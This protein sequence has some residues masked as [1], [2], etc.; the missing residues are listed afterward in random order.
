V[1]HPAPKLTVTADAYVINIHDRIVGSSSLYGSG[2]AVNSPAVVAAINANGNVLDPTVTQTGINIFTNAAN[3]RN[4]GLELLLSY[5]SNYGDMDRVDW[6]P[7]GNYNK[8]EVTKINQAPAQLLPQLLLNLGAIAS[9]EESSPRARVNFGALWKNHG[10][11]VN[12][13]ESVYGPSAG[14]T[15]VNGTLYFKSEIK[16]AATTDLE[17]SKQLTKS[18]T[19]A[20]GANNLFN[21]YPDRN[22]ADLITAQNAALNTGSVNQYPGFSPFGINGGYYYGRVN[23]SF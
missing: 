10:W 8:V 13:R 3:T 17:I 4:T 11:T 23:Y 5:A 2:A 19:L 6:S 12:L 21:K 20:V 7:A 9:L 18:L 16:T 14:Y 15:T 22:N 1:L